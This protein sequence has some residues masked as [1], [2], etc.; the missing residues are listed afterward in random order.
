M[1]T[2]T[3][4]AFI[5]HYHPVAICPALSLPLSPPSSSSPNT[6]LRPLTHHSRILP[7]SSPFSSSPNYINTTTTTRVSSSS[8]RRPQQQ[9]LAVIA[10]RG[11]V[12]ELLGAVGPE[13]AHA[14]QRTPLD[15]VEARVAAAE[16]VFQFVAHLFW[17]DARV[18]CV[19]GFS[20]GFCV[21]SWRSGFSLSLLRSG[22]VAFHIINE[23]G[24]EE[25]EFGW[26][27]RCSRPVSFM[28]VAAVVVVASLLASNGCWRWWCRSERFWG[29]RRRRGRLP[30]T[31]WCHPA[32]LRG[33]VGCWR[34]WCAQQD[35]SL[36][37]KG[38]ECSLMVLDKR[39]GACPSTQLE[40][41]PRSW[42]AKSEGKM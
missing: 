20:F 35:G 31:T 1:Q 21:F 36:D 26:G 17:V 9:R 11:K 14:Q 41:G 7:S 15:L 2:S 39:K 34:A 12:E 33:G 23:K 30:R 25:M 6:S 27:R 28:V 37:E 13:A 22:R 5:V 19:V 4:H 24:K 18:V 3:K 16:P 38:L 40:G 10:Q 8:L 29:A 42:R 32:M